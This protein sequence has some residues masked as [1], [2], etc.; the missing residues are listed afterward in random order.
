MDLPDEHL[1]SQI[2]ILVN[3]ILI[4]AGGHYN[5]DLPIGRE[6]M[7]HQKLQKNEIESSQEQTLHLIVGRGIGFLARHQLTF[8]RRAHKFISYQGYTFWPDLSL[9]LGFQF[10]GFIKRSGFRHDQTNREQKGKFIPRVSDWSPYP[11]YCL[12]TRE[13]HGKCNGGK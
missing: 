1:T 4:C 6:C 7:L 2:V 8:P 12:I 10:S 5:Q 13:P 3:R 11:I 9:D